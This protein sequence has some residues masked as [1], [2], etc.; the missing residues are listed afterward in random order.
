MTCDYRQR[1]LCPS[2]AAIDNHFSEEIA[3]VLSA[4]TRHAIRYDR[5]ISD[6]ESRWLFVRDLSL[7]IGVFDLEQ[8]G[9]RWSARRVTAGSSPGAYEH[10]QVLAAESRHEL[11]GLMRRE[12]DSGL[13]VRLLQSYGAYNLVTYLRKY[14]ALPLCLGHVNITNDSD[15]NKPGIL[16]AGTLDELKRLCGYS[17]PPRLVG[18]TNGYNLVAYDEKY[19]GIPQSFGPFDLTN[20]ENRARLGIQVA[21]T[22]GA[23]E[24]MCGGSLFNILAGAFVEMRPHKTQRSH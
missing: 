16:V 19:W 23:L 11:H 12:A 21:N 24:R 9:K 18:S 14:W 6:D 20:P 10:G 3:R 5:E 1:C 8:N 15:R 4:E 13:D 17:D 22:R 2:M 7:N